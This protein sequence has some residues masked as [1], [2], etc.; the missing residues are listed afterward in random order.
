MALR[1]RRWSL[2]WSVTIDHTLKGCTPQT[3]V[4]GVVSNAANTKWLSLELLSAL[5]WG[6]IVGALWF[7]VV[8]SQWPWNAQLRLLLEASVVL[9][10]QPSVCSTDTPWLGLSLSSLGF[11]LWCKSVCR[12][13]W[14]VHKTWSVVFIQRHM[15]SVPFHELVMTLGSFSFCVSHLVL[16]HVCHPSA[17]RWSFCSTSVSAYTCSVFFCCY[18]IGT[19]EVFQSIMD[20][21]FIST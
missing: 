5:F 8:P 18:Y 15:Y 13:N 2:F 14:A 19:L 17:R 9:L 21:W 7:W 20:S 3:S 16:L 11:Y 12:H 1:K 6:C 10:E 4:H